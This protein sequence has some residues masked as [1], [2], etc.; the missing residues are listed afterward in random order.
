MFF[1]IEIKKEYMN[2]KFCCRDLQHN[3]KE[4]LEEEISLVK[5]LQISCLIMFN[6]QHYTK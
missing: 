6:F 4:I 3:R 1:I 2:R 5:R